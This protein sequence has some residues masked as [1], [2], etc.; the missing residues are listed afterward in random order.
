M[1]EKHCKNCNERHLLT[2]FSKS[3]KATDGYTSSCKKS[4]LEKLA[5]TTR[6]KGIKEEAYDGFFNVH[7]NNGEWIA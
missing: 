3:Y 7:K 4:R 5:N 2:E 6:I 1:T